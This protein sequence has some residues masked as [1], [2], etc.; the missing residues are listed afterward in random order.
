MHARSNESI[1]P[2]AC[3]HLALALVALVPLAGAACTS[4]PPA[5]PNAVGGPRA[6]AI[7]AAASSDASAPA[8]PVFAQCVLHAG[9]GDATV[10]RTRK[11]GEP[12]D[13]GVIEAAVARCWFN[14]ECVAMHGHVTPTDGF[15][16]LACAGT[17]CRCVLHSVAQPRDPDVV[18][19]FEA[20][21]PC[22]DATRARELL[23]ARCMTGMSM[24]P[25]EDGGARQ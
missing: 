13:A 23:L 8:R 18:E 10:H 14:A 1:A 5:S 6:I 16:D 3:R 24:A 22:G 4:A 19:S 7:R 21:D 12:P 25:D 9:G 20:S 2:I 11:P 17:R 15:V